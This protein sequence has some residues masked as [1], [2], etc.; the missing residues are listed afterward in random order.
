MSSKK[1]NFS[2]RADYKPVQNIMKQMDAFFQESRKR[3]N[4]MVHEKTFQIETEELEHEFIIKALLPGYRRDQIKL[5]TIGNQLRIA[6]KEY[7]YSE[8][9]DDKTGEWNTERTA[10]QLERTVPLPF[11]ITEAD[12]HAKHR[13]G[14]LTVSIPKKKIDHQIIDIE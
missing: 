2:N 1:G 12:I 9:K 14:L 6:V 4:A 13:D 8:S 11:V 7:S 5:Q 3:L 10:K